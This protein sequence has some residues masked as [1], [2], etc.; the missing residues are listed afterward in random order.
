MNRSPFIR[1]LFQGGFFALPFASY[2]GIVGIFLGMLVIGLGHSKAIFSYLY[3]TGFLALS[4]GLIGVSVLAVQP[5][6]SFL[7]LANYLPYFLLLGS[8]VIWL[9]SFPPTGEY[10]FRFLEDIAH[11]FLWVSIPI[12]GIAGVEYGLR[13]PSIKAS[14]TH[15]WL[16]AWI[17]SGVD[18]G[19]R[20]RAVFEH[21][22]VMACY[23]T[24]VFCLGMGLVLAAKHSDQVPRQS[25]SSFKSTWADRLPLLCNTNWPWLTGAT[26]FN[27]LGIFCSGS[28]N[29]LLIVIIILLCVGCFARTSRKLKLVSLVGVGAVISSA[30]VI[31]VGG[32]QISWAWVDSDPRVI[33]WQIAIKLVQQRPLTGWGLGSY[34]LLYQP[35]TI[36]G[37]DA[38]PHAHNLWLMLASEAGLPMTISLTMVVG[39]LCYR[40]VRAYLAQPAASYHQSLMMGYLLAF[41]S[42]ILF[43]LF[44]VALFDARVNIPAWFV[45]AAI[46][47]FPSIA[48]PRQPQQ[49]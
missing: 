16:V 32:R 9:T 20:A 6:E 28:R 11:I 38:I 35:Q 43:S 21:P 30:I 27:L 15:P 39:L 13:S 47:A 45:L 44:D 34:K 31:G 49:N 5:S 29:G 17:N 8:F 12:N 19:H 48:L 7:Q 2:L 3:R 24:I 18:Y 14:L 23:L 22:N 40:G 36:P 1:Q 46:A 41:L 25:D 42:C 10:A 33:A 26:F 4:V 37:Y